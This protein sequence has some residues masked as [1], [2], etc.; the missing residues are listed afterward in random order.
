MKQPRHHDLELQS[1]LE[2][3]EDEES[4]G[5]SRAA[6]LVQLEGLCRLKYA[7]AAT[8]RDYRSKADPEKLKLKK[9]LS[10]MKIVSREKVTSDRVYSCAYH[11]EKVRLSIYSRFLHNDFASRGRISSFSVTST[12]SWASGTHGHLPLLRVMTRI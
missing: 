5:K 11:P 8:D 7:R 2:S 10:G 1:V 6:L 4:T 9:G 12:A 3:E